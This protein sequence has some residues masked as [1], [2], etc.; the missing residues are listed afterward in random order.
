LRSNAKARTSHAVNVASLA[1]DEVD[2]A[3]RE[4]RGGGAKRRVHR[5][6][7]SDDRGGEGGEAI[8]RRV[9]A[10]RFAPTK[11]FVAEAEH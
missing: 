10:R 5:V 4:A 9:V 3:K 1:V 11:A 8:R 2:E 6:E 7:A